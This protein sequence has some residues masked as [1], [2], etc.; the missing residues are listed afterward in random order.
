MAITSGRC[1]ALAKQ[2]PIMHFYDHG[3]PHPNDRIVS[4]AFLSSYE[5]VESG[6]AHH[7]Q[8]RRQVKMSGLDITAVAS[9]NQFIRSNLPAA[10][11]QNAACAGVQKKDESAYADP[12]NGE[13][14]GIR[15]RVSADFE[16]SIS[17][18]SPGTANSI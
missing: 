5:D 1:F 9:A 14:A 8:A 7:R 12:D 13:S 18:T 10:A 3:K 17:A 6:K 2:V 4:A 11:G 16:P 15:S